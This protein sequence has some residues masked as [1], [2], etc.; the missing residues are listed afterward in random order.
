MLHSTLQPG[1]QGT[2]FWLAPCAHLKSGKRGCS[3][4]RLIR[5][6]LWTTAWNHT[7][8]PGELA[9]AIASVQLRDHDNTDGLLQACQKPRSQW[10][11]SGWYTVHPD[12][13][14]LGGLETSQKGNNQSIQ[15]SN[16]CRSFGAGLQMHKP[17]VCA[18]LP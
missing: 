9:T 15:L 10:V 6:G 14:Q 7:L 2:R 18:F 3:Q 1:W 17:G 5:P 13:V 12:I 16:Q 8:E 11:G 4:V